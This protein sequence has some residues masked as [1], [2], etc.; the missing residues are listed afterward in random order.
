MKEL[1]MTEEQARQNFEVI[2]TAEGILGHYIIRDDNKIVA[3]TYAAKNTDQPE[4]YVGYIYSTEE[5]YKHQL[6]AKI[7]ELCREQGIYELRSFLF[8][9]MI[10]KLNEYEKMGFKK[11]SNSSMYEKEI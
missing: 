9:G 5:K 2:E 10:P 1:E 3:R 6:I 7:V 4:V 8:G 11:L